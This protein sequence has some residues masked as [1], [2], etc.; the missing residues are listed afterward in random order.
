MSDRKNTTSRTTKSTPAKAPKA[1]TKRRTAQRTPNL[2]EAAR[3]TGRD[4]DV[5]DYVR[6]ASAILAT[7]ALAAAGYLFRGELGELLVDAVRTATAGGKTA[8]AATTRATDLARTTARDV[9]T[10]VSTGVSL[11]SIL[12]YAGLQRRSTMRSIIGPAAGML[13]G[14]VVGS[15]VTHFFGDTLLA[16][17]RGQAVDNTNNI[18]E[19]VSGGT[20]TGAETDSAMSV[21]QVR[22]NGG[23]PHRSIS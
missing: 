5:S 22:P 7:G 23:V 8:A 14:V 19:G 15:V 12:H 9:A 1:R 11:D 16:Q 3:K 17:L 13:C 20:E 10:A 6:P 2:L 18:G 21:D 4:F